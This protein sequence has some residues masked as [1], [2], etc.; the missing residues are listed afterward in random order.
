MGTRRRNWGEDAIAVHR[1]LSLSAG[2]AALGGLSACEGVQSALDPRGHEAQVVADLFWIMLAGAVVIWCAVLGLAFYATKVAPSRDGRRLADGL[3]I[4]GGVIFPVVVLTALLSYG[5]FLMPELRA[6]NG[7]LR[8]TV[9]GEQWWWRVAYQPPGGVSTVMDA[10]EIRLPVGERVE[11]L[12]ESP[13]VIHALWIPPLGGKIDMIPGRVNRIVLQASE[14]GIFRGVCAEYC[15]D[16]HALMAFSAVAMEPDAFAVWLDHIAGPAQEPQS[17]QAE[18]GRR[19]FL[20]SGC[21]GCHA[22]R[23]TPADG[24]I[25]PDLT[26]VGGRESLAAGILP[27]TVDALRRWIA[28]PKQVKPGAKMPSF[29]M[30]PEAEIEAMAVYLN[31]LK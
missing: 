12:V 10:N 3:I 6:E 5:L 18:E 21:G 13:D 22:I 9:S 17:V 24:V 11:F 25:G 16:S 4:G 31:G 15:G 30:L 8:V 29:A 1:A 27:N 28:H 2:L 26:H 14:A 19:L 23:G 7:G 20:A